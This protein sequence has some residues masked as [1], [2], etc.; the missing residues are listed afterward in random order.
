MHGISLDL[1]VNIQ[2][3]LQIVLQID[4]LGFSAYHIAARVQLIQINALDDLAFS[5]PDRYGL[6][7]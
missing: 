4:A 5:Q 2:P 1:A 7:G 6:A 3:N